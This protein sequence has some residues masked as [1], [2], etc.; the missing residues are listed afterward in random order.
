MRLRVLGS[1]KG[2]RLE[3]WVIPRMMA[4]LTLSHNLLASRTRVWQGGGCAAG[5]LAPL[6]AA[7]AVAREE[8][9]YI[10]GLMPAIVP[11]AGE[12]STGVG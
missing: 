11:I 9:A 7:A 6:A 4:R 5:N 3:T 2:I 1:S 10:W 8:I 12:G